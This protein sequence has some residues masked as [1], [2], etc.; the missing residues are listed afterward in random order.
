VLWAWWYW[1]DEVE[2]CGSH[3]SKKANNKHSSLLSF[4]K[5]RKISVN[6][7]H[8]PLQGVRIQKL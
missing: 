5:Y 6:W 8:L 4:E 3:G 1:S 7:W 2:N